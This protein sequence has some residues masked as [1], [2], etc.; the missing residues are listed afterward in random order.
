M[1]ESKGSTF[2]FLHLIT[3]SMTVL[4]CVAA[5]EASEHINLSKAGSLPWPKSCRRLTSVS[6]KVVALVSIVVVL[7]LGF[8]TPI[9]KMSDILESATCS[10]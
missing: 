2:T 5:S 9:F 3:A 1:E 4:C 7:L 10:N 8:T 6:Y